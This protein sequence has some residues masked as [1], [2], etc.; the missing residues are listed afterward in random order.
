MRKP[1]CDGTPCQSATAGLCSAEEPNEENLRQGAFPRSSGW[2]IWERFRRGLNSMRITVAAAL[3]F[4]TVGF[5]PMQVRAQC[6]GCGGLVG[7]L[8]GGIIGGA[9]AGSIA[10]SAQPR[11][12][13]V[14]Q[15]RRV[16][17]VKRAAAPRQRV[18]RSR[19]GD[20]APQKAV[21]NASA[22]PFANS[23]SSSSAEPTPVSA[24]Q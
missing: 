17:H 13:Y 6:Y 19:G 15:Q 20:G 14:I 4:G 22:D 24:K 2:L 18:V 21:I 7:G 9:I 12:V 10:A 11:P 16:V 5:L 23:K 8:A 3:V 1:S